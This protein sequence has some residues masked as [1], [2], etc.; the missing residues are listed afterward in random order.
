MMSP[1]LNQ[2]GENGPVLEIDDSISDQSRYNDLIE[3]NRELLRG[4]REVN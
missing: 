1:T 3:L 4:D 2:T